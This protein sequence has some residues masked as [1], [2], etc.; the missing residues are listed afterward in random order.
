MSRMARID[1]R[2][3]HALW[4]TA[5][6]AGVSRRIFLGLLATGGAAGV[7][8]ACAPKVVTQTVTASPAPSPAP[9]SRLFHGPIPDQ[10]F[11]P[12]GSNAEMRFDVMGNRA[13]QTPSS[14][15]F[16]RNHSSSP[17]IDV[18]TWKLSVLGDGVDRPFDLS[19]DELLSMP[20]TTVTRFIECAGNG[21]SFFTS[22]LN[23]PA[24]GGQWLLGAYGIADWT[25]VKL[26]ALLDRARI[27]SSAV[28]VMPTGLDSTQVERP[29]SVAKALEDDTIVAYL[30]NGDILPVDHGFPARLITPGWVGI[31]NIKWVSRVTVST[32]PVLVEKNTS[33][34]VLIGPDYQPRPPARGPALTTQVM[35][36]ACALPWPA[37]LSPGQQRVAGYAWSPLGKISGVSVSLDNGSTFSDARLTGPNIERAGSRWEYVFNAIP[38]SMTITPRATDEKG[39]TQYGLEQQKWNEQGYLFGAVAPHPVTVA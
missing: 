30:M 10:F 20:S 31:A 3:V 2:Q 6:S 4:R 21:R 38:G 13:Y 5:E 34:Y 15:F 27:K 11:I 33:S 7:L 25:G 28:D 18:R 35:K 39:N 19:Y 12:I 23:R 22:L 29:M 37:K 9:S 36:S 14:M 32:K 1:D 26:S 17:L 8:A 24:Q 16:I